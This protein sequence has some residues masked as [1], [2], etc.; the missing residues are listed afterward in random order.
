MSEARLVQSHQKDCYERS[1]AC[2]YQV[3]LAETAMTNMREARLVSSKAS[4]VSCKRSK[5]CTKE[6]LL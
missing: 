6:R 2:K 4:I 3:K 1:E 5:A